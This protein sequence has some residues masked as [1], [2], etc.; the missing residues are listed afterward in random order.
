MNRKNILTIATMISSVACFALPAIS[1]GDCRQGCDLTNLN[2][3]LGED[4]LLSN[5]SGSHNTAVGYKALTDNTTGISNTAVGYWAL[6]NNTASGN[7]AVGHTALW[8][9][10]SG[11]SNTAVGINA[12]SQNTT[13]P[14]NTAI[15]DD[16]L[17]SNTTGSTNTAL[18]RGALYGNTTGSDNIAIGY[19]SLVSTPGNKNVAIGNLA[20]YST[21]GSENT[22]IGYA[23]LNDNTGNYNTV[24]GAYALWNASGFLYNASYCTASG[25]KT[26]Y[27]NTS[28]NSNTANGYVALYKNTTGYSNTASGNAALYSNTTGHHNVGLGNYAGFSLTTGSNNIDIA[29]LGVAGESGTIRI[30]TS[31]TQTATY[32]AGIRGTTVPTGI[33]VLIDTAGRLGTTTSSARFKAN[34]KPMENASEA[35][36][37]L[38]PVTFRYKEELDPEGIP[39]FG[40]VAE[41]VEKINPDLVAHD[42]EGKP[43][44]VRYE[45]VNAMLLNEFLKAHRKMEEQRALNQT[46]ETTIAQQHKRIEALELALKAQTAQ[47]QQIAAQLDGGQNSVQVADN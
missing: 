32:I 38:E 26:L 33:T 15:G 35:I 7:T 41:Q 36:L 31:G 6:L 21:T 23:A 5:T 40:L 12:L 1:R 20:Q 13:G 22:A 42:E 14:S 25:Y 29:N 24:I 4:A 46:Q 18:G 39:Q 19:D 43:Y 47:I 37:A 17:Y 8:L 44:S 27:N 9:N 11:Y 16:A 2:T 34:I 45:A 28:G 30:G 10:T 3:Y